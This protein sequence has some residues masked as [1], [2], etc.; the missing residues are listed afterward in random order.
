MKRNYVL[1]ID[2]ERCIGCEACTVACRIEN[3]GAQG[4][5]RVSTLDTS[6]KDTPAGVFPNLKMVFFPSV[7]NHCENPPCVD[8]CPV[9]AIVRDDNGIV[10]LSREACDGCRICLDVCPYNAIAF[11]N[12]EDRAE[13]CNLCSHRIDE[14]LE[15]F[16]VICC[17]GQAIFFGDMKDPGSE[18]SK[19]VK[20]DKSYR[21]SPET[22]TEPKV[23]Y[24]PPKE[25]RGL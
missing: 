9:D 6:R 11:N 13:K 18:V 1:I 22:G 21:L 12:E 8:A 24:L 17:E 16:C 23:Y 25:P 20:E 3:S 19:L 2:Q 10:I 14:G 15:P 7:C 5:I 4:H